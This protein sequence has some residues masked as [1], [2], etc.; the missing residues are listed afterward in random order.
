M[1]SPFSGCLH[2]SSCMPPP[3]QPQEP[4]RL[5]FSNFGIKGPRNSIERIETRLYSYYA[6]KFT[7]SPILKIVRFV[8]PR[9]SDRSAGMTAGLRNLG[10]CC[11]MWA[12]MAR[13]DSSLPRFCDSLDKGCDRFPITHSIFDFLFLSAA[14]LLRDMHCTS[15]PSYRRQTSL[16]ET[17][18]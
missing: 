2:P 10:F 14:A 11:L 12:T 3:K 1:N 7:S 9:G 6:F 5:N 16:R 4:T 13:M 15:F 18:Y 8:T 17:I